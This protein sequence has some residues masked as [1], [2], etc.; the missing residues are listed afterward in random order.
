[1]E[2]APVGN[3]NCELLTTVSQLENVTWL[4]TRDI[5]SQVDA[6]TLIQVEHTAKRR[7]Q[8]KLPGTGNGVPPSIPPRARAGRGEGREVEE[9]VRGAC[10][11]RGAG[12]VGTQASG[13]A[14]S[15]HRRNKD[16]RQRRPAAYSP[17]RH[18]RPLSQKR[19]NQAVAQRSDTRKH[20][21]R[22]QRLRGYPVPLIEIGK[23]PS[24]RGSRQS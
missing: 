23:P 11:Q 16:R 15:L 5:Y 20:S 17:F 10:I 21:S 13:H 6:D 8:G 22:V 2:L 1:M 9:R 19:P 4:S 24:A 12:P 3:P 14:C 7:I 18:H